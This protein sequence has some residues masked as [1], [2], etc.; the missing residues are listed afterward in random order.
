M[1]FPTTCSQNSYRLSTVLFSSCHIFGGWVPWWDWTLESCAVRAESGKGGVPT[2]DLQ[3]P[4]SLPEGT[5]ACEP[6]LSSTSTR[7]RRFRKKCFAPLWVIQIGYALSVFMASQPEPRNVV[8][9]DTQPPS[10]FTFKTSTSYRHPC[11]PYHFLP[12]SHG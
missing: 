10:I 1:A 5:N 6:P 3:S 4:K 2:S 12:G 7:S 11:H 9:D 8:H